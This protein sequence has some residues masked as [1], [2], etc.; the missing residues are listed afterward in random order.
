MDT[1]FGVSVDSVG[2]S[3]RRLAAVV[4]NVANVVQ[5]GS[6]WARSWQTWPTA[7]DFG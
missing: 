2:V 3:E 7:G 5:I 1:T 4:S 6:P